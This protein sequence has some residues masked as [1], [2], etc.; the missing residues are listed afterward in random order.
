M[1]DLHATFGGLHATL[2]FRPGLLQ[3]SRG[4]NFRFDPHI[5]SMGSCGWYRRKRFCRQFPGSERSRMRDAVKTEKQPWQARGIGPH[6][7]PR[8][9]RLA[10]GEAHTILKAL[11]V[12]LLRQW[13]RNIRR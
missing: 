4:A 5:Q 8:S 2:E 11:V 7:L 10:N 6:L 1:R 13:Q 3:S 12:A 9:T